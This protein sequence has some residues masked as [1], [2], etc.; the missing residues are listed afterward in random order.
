MLVYIPLSHFL[1]NLKSVKRKKNTSEKFISF[2]F[3]I[4]DADSLSDIGIYKNEETIF[5]IID[6]LTLRSM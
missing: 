6:K 5:L 4:N 3:G 1:L 2:E